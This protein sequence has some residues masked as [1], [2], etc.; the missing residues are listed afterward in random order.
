VSAICVYPGTLAGCSLLRLRDSARKWG[1]VDQNV[2]ILNMFLDNQLVFFCRIFFLWSIQSSNHSNPIKSLW[3]FILL[4][5]FPIFVGTCIFMYFPSPVPFLSPISPDLPRC[6]RLRDFS[7]PFFE[8][9]GNASCRVRSLGQNGHGLVRIYAISCYIWN[10][11]ISIIYI[12]I[13]ITCITIV[14]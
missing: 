13:Y 4:L 3:M 8:A 5:H 11:C 14:T 10:L 7:Q 2:N 6:R 9:L 12:N 1:L